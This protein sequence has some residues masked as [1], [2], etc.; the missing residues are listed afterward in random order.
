M[1]QTSIPYSLIIVAVVILLDI[2]V[3]YIFK[4]IKEKLPLGVQKSFL[5]FVR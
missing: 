2:V 5:S 1:L 3:I 4:I